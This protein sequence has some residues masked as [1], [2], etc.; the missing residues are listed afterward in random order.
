MKKS[1][2]KLLSVMLVF[3]FCVSMLTACGG[4]QTGEGSNATVTPA[5]G[6]TQGTTEEGNAET[7]A[8]PTVAEPAM[9]LGGM[10]IVLGDWWTSDQPAEPKTQQ[11]EDTLAYRTMIQEKYNFTMKQVAITDWGGMQELFTTS[12]MAS[13]PAAQVF[14]LQP[15]WTSQPLAN[16]LLYDLATLSSLDFSES[17][18]NENVVNIMTYG[19]SVYGM[20]VGNPEPR[21]GVFWNKRLFQEAGLDPDLPYDLQASNEWTWDKFEELCKTLTRDTNNDGTIDTYAMVSFSVDFFKAMMTSDNAVFIGKDASGKFYNATTEPQFL[22]S[23]QWAVSMI[24]KGYEMPAPEGSN[25][26]WF[27]AAFHDAKVAMQFAEQY[28]V[29]TWADMTDDWGFVNCPKPKIED[30][31]SVYF[32]D[33]IAVI[34]Y[35]A[36]LLII[37]SEIES[38]VL[39]F[40]KSRSLLST[41]MENSFSRNI[42]NCIANKEFTKPNENKS[43]SSLNS[44][45]LKNL[46]KKVLILT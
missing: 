11:E 31:Y 43:S 10:D 23:M 5:A 2:K 18:W 36:F 40:F 28:K 17:K 22:E 16:G 4:N 24:Q 3:A 21:G 14:L 34:P 37:N 44:C 19:K 1:L 13:E 20:A 38:T 25:W 27:V 12:V 33:N 26:D 46:D 30:P 7:V 32:G 9:D 8:T 6:E 42:T 35:H 15:N 45:F 41:L 39:K 29:G